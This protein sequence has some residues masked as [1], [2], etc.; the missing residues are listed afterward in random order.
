MLNAMRRGAQTWVAKLLFVLLVLSFG[1]WGVS[2]SLLGGGGDAVVTVGDTEVSPNEFRLAYDRQLSLLSQQFGTRLTREQA[3]A[4]GVENQVYSQLVAGAA[5]DELADDMNLGLSESRL[6]GLIAEDPAFQGIDGQFSRQNFAYVLN[7]VGMSQDDYVRNREQVAVRTQ[8][9]EALSDGF[10][11]PQAM[12]DA[13]SRHRAETRTVNY[14]LLDESMIEPVGTPDDEA[15]QAYFEEN[16]DRYRAPEYREIA[17]VALTAQALADPQTISDEEVRAEFEANAADY[18]TPERRTIEQLIF[19]DQEAAEAAAQRLAEGE[20]FDAI[21]AEQGRTVEDTRLGTFTRG[22]MTN[23]ALAEAAFSI[24]EAGGT[25]GVVDGP[26]GPVIL[27]VSSIEDGGTSPI[28]EVSDEIRQRLAETEAADLLFDVY[29]SYEDARAGGMSLQDAARQQGLD[30]VVVTVD[31][32]GRTPDGEVVADIPESRELLATAFASDVGIQ[33]PPLSI[34]SAGYVWFEVL[35]VEEARDRT[36]DEVRDEVVEDWRQDQIAAA[37][38]ARAEELE[39]RLR[40][41]G[42]L[43]AIAADLG[44][45]M[46]TEYGLQ[47]NSDDPMFGGEA[48][49]AAF[50]GPRG[51]IDV[52][53]TAEN[54]S[55]LIMQVAEIATAA[56]ESLPEQ[57]REALAAQTSGGILDELVMR[58]QRE[59]LVSI[60]RALGEQALAY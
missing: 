44:T 43:E 20:T 38:S 25:S 17:Y 47:R 3:R 16:Q 4:F 31:Q 19:P 46:Q 15:L 50:A 41:G 58:L 1:V 36:L 40:E 52:A 6:A 21:A 37:L 34:G 24:E 39:A 26:F 53:P 42:S 5:L 30:P 48:I 10:D 14:V 2:G 60:N 29:D 8:V 22:D 59:Y 13:L 54:A 51:H 18:S 27:R 7:Q 11:A 57:E 33:E 23:E 45:R 55:R 32:S 56:G 28:Q 49:E 12:I 35:N 9:I